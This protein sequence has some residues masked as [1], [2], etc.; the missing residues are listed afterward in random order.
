MR[1]A[2]Q[3]FIIGTGSKM[4]SAVE[5]R[6]MPIERTRLAALRPASRHR[7][8]GSAFAPSAHAVERDYRLIEPALVE[9]AVHD[10]ARDRSVHVADG[11][12]DALA[13]IARRVAVAQLERFPFTGRRP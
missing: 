9:L 6:D 12:L 7:H 8:A 5:R 2:I 13:V 1:T 4:R 10:R 3:M 11:L